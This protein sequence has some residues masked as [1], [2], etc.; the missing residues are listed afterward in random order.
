MEVQPWPHLLAH[1]VLP[2]VP[3]EWLPAAAL[4]CR[5][6]AALVRSTAHWEARVGVE[7][8]APSPLG[9]LS[10]CGARWLVA[11][12]ARPR[13]IGDDVYRGDVD[14]EG[15]PHGAGWLESPNGSLRE[16]FWVEGRLDGPGAT[17]TV[18]ARPFREQ[19]MEERRGTFERDLQVGLG[20]FRAGDTSFQ[21]QFVAHA[22][23]KGRLLLSNG[24]S[25]E[26]ELRDGREHGAGTFR[27]AASGDT[28]T[29]QTW[30]RGRLQ[31]EATYLWGTG[32]WL[33]GTYEDGSLVPNAL[34]HYE[35]V[36]GF[37]LDTPFADNVPVRPP[38]EVLPPLLRA[39]LARG[40]CL[41]TATGP[42]AWGQPYM[43]LKVVEYVPRLL[44]YCV[45][46]WRVC[47]PRHRARG[48]HAGL[49][50]VPGFSGNFWC[51]CGSGHERFGD[52]ACA[53]LVPPA[54]DK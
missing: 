34:A 49:E 10:A 9:M 7:R 43:R 17:R 33:R 28:I 35:D 19:Y 21:G 45:V 47:A 37:A 22:L 40:A 6:W 39:A 16:G 32:N 50:F 13:P 18:Y 26:G 5:S 15:R 25:Y 31:G 52:G 11:A 20:T 36:H 51:C 8:L 12:H 14:A 54:L 46:C 1:F 44:G 53:C 23:V 24:N 4:T 41:Y 42:Q 2:H 48:L 38:E 30:H 3:L 29:C 27:I